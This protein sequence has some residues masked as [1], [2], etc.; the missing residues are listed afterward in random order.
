M[1]HMIAAFITI[2]LLVAPARAELQNGGEFSSM[3]EVAKWIANYRTRPDPARLPAAVRAL[4][5]LGAFKEP[6]GAGIY[7]GFIA[8]VLGANPDKAEALIAKMLSIAPVDQWV[9][10]RGIAYSAHPDWQQWLRKFADRMP[11]RKTMIEHYL[12]GRSPTLYE[13]PLERKEPT[14]WDKVVGHFQSRHT[15]KASGITL[16][17]SPDLLD[18]LWGYYFATGSQR[19]IE[20]IIT[21][22]PWAN[23]R[24]NVDK[25]TM[26]NMAKYTLASNAARDAPLLA[27]LKR[28]AKTAP[29]R[30]AAVLN[31]VIEAAET[32]ETTRLRKDALASIEELKRKGPGSKREISS[33]GL[34]GQG[35]LAIGCIAAA[36]T[37]HVELGLPCIIGGAASGAAMSYWNGQQ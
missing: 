7:L 9:I 5:Q 15:S 4:S 28:D 32:V 17:K 34:I 31:E 11:M 8:G 21:L 13:V 23:E 37:G 33:W 2:V 3:D 12:D 18:T 14:L 35:A 29:R 10:V 20:R 26:G 36:A 6:E 30:V 27:L 19:P 25:L 16:D 24:D 22:L 1:R